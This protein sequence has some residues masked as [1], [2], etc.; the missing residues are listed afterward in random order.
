M[1]PNYRL[2]WPE[3][4]ALAV[5]F[6]VGLLSFAFN[7]WSLATWL[8]EGDLWG[9]ARLVFIAWAIMRFLDWMVGGPTMRRV[10]RLARQGP[11][12][13]DVPYRSKR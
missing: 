6:F 4:G 2:A 1:D 3:R 5:A 8:Q 12:V 11:Q 7:E 10:S 9:L 13:I